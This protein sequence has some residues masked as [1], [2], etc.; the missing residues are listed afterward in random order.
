MEAGPNEG[1][2]CLLTWGPRSPQEFSQDSQQPLPPWVIY[3]SCT[4]ELDR[5]LSAL[6]SGW[7]TIYQVPGC[8][9]PCGVEPFP[10]ER[11][12]CTAQTEAGVGGLGQHHTRSSGVD[13]NV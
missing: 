8:P 9:G 7:K 10:R 5:F 2:L 4:S 1:A 3:L 6:N 12:P 13:M 11:S